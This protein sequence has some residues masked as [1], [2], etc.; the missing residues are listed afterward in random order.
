M[1]FNNVLNRELIELNMVAK[2][3][4]EVINEMAGMLF[5]SGAITSKEAFV[6][7]VFERERIGTTGV[8]MGIA[9]PH[10]RSG[11][12]INTSI[13]I[14][15]L[16]EPVD[17]D[18]LDGKPVSLVF[19]LAVPKDGGE[20][21]HLKLLSGIA[22]MLMEEDF[23]EKLFNARDKEEVLNIMGFTKEDDLK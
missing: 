8:G 14:A 4:E 12:V 17:W 1:I 7:D 11:S 3:K 18:S 23:R 15:K 6:N 22:S 20:N 5:K 10:G 16:K 9:I 21:I 13:A 19:L 2:T